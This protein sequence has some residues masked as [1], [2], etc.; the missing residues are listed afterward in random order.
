MKS[1]YDVQLWVLAQRQMADT[2]LISWNKRVSWASR[3]FDIH[4][5]NVLK[6]T[7]LDFFFL[8]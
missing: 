1:A 6:E 7:I 4:M 2:D 5:P 8:N 3:V